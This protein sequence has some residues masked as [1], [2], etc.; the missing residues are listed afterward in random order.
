MNTIND[1]NY[2]FNYQSYKL[3]K[4]LI[5]FY[6]HLNLIFDFI[7]FYILHF[8]IINHYNYYY[9]NKDNISYIIIH[10]KTKTII[11]IIHLKLIKTKENEN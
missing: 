11:I 10:S 1:M 4:Q 3:K 2:I 8:I 6:N 7:S 5:F 9:H